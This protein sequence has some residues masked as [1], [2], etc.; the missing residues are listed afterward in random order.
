[1]SIATMARCFQDL[2]NVIGVKDSTAKLRRISQQRLACKRSGGPEFI[3][4][5]GEDAT[6]VGAGEPTGGHGCI[7]VTA[8]AA[9]AWQQC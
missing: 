8:A 4:L 9:Q 3:Q 1:M 5:S 7:S 6:A 2:K